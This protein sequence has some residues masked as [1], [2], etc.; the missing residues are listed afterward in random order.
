MVKQSKIDKEILEKLNLTFDKISHINNDVPYS[1]KT[2]FN[3]KGRKSVDIISEFIKL[4]SDPEDI[5]LD[6]FM[7]SGS[8]VIAS[9][10][11]SK[12]IIGLELDNY[13]YS[14]VKTLFTKIDN[15]LLEEY[16]NNVKQD[17]FKEIMDL[18]ETTCCGV[19]NHIDKLHFDPENQEYFN[20]LPH[21]DIKDGKNIIMTEKC[22][23]CNN[24]TK[25]F[26]DDDMTVIT[27]LESIDTSRF[28]NHKLIENSRINITAT[29]GAD[30]YDTNFTKR[31]K[32][33]LLRLQ[34]SINQLPPS[35][36]RDF[37]EHCLVASL[38]IARICQY[39]AGS[40]Y[41]YQV[42]RTQAQEK[43]VW[44][45]FESKYDAFLKFQ[46]E[47]SFMLKS[48]QHPRLYNIYNTDYRDFLFKGE[49]DYTQYFNMIVTDPP[50]TDQ[51][52]FLERSQMYRDWLKEFYDSSMTLTEEMLTKEVVVTNSPT[53]KDK[54]D[55]DQYYKDID[56]MFSDF[57]TILKPNGVILFQFKLGKNKYLKTLGEYINYARKNGFEVSSSLGI[58]KNDPSLRKQAAF[59]N[60]L[61]KEILI[62]FV[63]VSEE[64]RY[65][66]FDNTNYEEKINQTVY[67]ELKSKPNGLQLTKLI[68]LILNDIRDNFGILNFEKYT[69]KI[70]SI[71]KSN[72]LISDNSQVT[73]DPNRLYL[74][75]EESSD[76]FAKLYDV[77]PVII[78][79]FDKVEGFTLDDLY[80]EIFVN[81]LSG[82]TNI[83][84]K[85]I[86]D[87]TYETQI[88][89]LL[90]NYCDHNE[91]RYF[92]RK[93]KNEVND[94]A[95]D[96]SSMDGYEFEELIRRLL[97]KQGYSDVIR[98]G[99]ACD[100]GVDLIAKKTIN[101]QTQGYIF[102][103]KRWIGNVGGTPIQRLHSMRIQM[104]PTITNAICI[105][106]SNYTSAAINEAKNT[107]VQ[108]VNGNELLTQL[109]REFPGE[110]YHGA[111][112]LLFENKGMDD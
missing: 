37:L 104:Q 8:F 9:E 62:S 49:T 42:M 112:A 110:Y 15:T 16:F 87:K 1:L 91:N 77:I 52:P 100:R 30:Y 94:T 70:S 40:E 48:D 7:G 23:V 3:F 107:S 96:I 79:S 69:D 109:E 39:G 4:Y 18:Y 22:P 98:I 27:R 68:T 83:L 84:E 5:L 26:T 64:N 66:Y 88:K 34:D 86:T 105:T 75:L 92:L 73:I 55:F 32:I 72:F 53:R 65:L 57:Y 111:L 43:N 102:Q 14:A 46:N 29:S 93:A 28:P 78:R 61:T 6:P 38:T 54:N 97:V 106:T 56:R 50:Y 36:E 33:A 59:L 17:C 99:G 74:S 20:P 12:K 71:I 81:L 60:T 95:I 80:Y 90:N 19:Q 47:F 51:V 103:C 24:K 2:T 21:R 44:Q 82:E 101:S 85:I 45:L 89:N 76:L 31:A 63:K 67:N 25:S 108:L 35:L 11:A 10:K 41:I 13:T 58:D